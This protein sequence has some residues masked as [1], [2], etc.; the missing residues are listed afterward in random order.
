MSDDVAAGVPGGYSAPAPPSDPV[1]SM[2]NT[3]DRTIPRSETRRLVA[4]R[5]RFTGDLTAPRMLHAAFLRSPVA[6]GRIA[7]LDV[8]AARA[9]PGVAAV[10]TA[11]DLRPVCRPMVTRSA[12]VAEHRPPPQPALADGSVHYQG[13]PVALA[14]ADGLDRARDAAEAVRLEIDALP[15]ASDYADPAVRSRK[16][17]PE[18]DSNVMLRRTFGDSTGA[19]STARRRFVFERQ[20]GVPLEGRAVLADYDPSEGSLT[21][22][23]S[24]QVP[25]QMQDVWAGLLGLPLHRM[26][27][28]CPDVGGAFG[29]KL[30]AYADELA[31][32]AASRLLGR[33]VKWAADRLESFLSDVHAREFVIEAGLETGEDGALLAI[34][35]EM[36]NGAGAYSV[37]PRASA[38]E[39]SLTAAVIGAAYSAG[40][41]RV[42]A[43]ARAQNKTPTGAYRGVGQP[44]AMAVTEVL[45]D[46]AAHRLGLD[47]LDLRRR[48]Y[49]T[50]GA[51]FAST[52]G[53]RADALSLHACLDRL[54]A[55]MDYP[56]LRAAQA[57]AR[58]AGRIEGIGVATLIELTAPGAA[59][60]GAQEIDVTAEDT[61]TVAML[62]SGAVRVQ[63][64]CTDQGQGTL[65]GVGQL[66]GERLGLPPADVAVTAGD[67]AGPV[68][69]GAWASRGLAIGGTAAWRAAD[70]VAVRLLEIAATLLQ[71]DTANLRLAGGH[72]ID[73]SG[74]ARLPVAEIAKIAHYRQHL[75]P[76]ELSTDLSA[77]R[78]FVPKTAPF[79]AANGIHACHLAI[80]PETGAIDLLNHWVAEDCGRVINP[81]LVDGQ[82]IGG[83]VQGLGAALME[84][85]VYDG[86]GNLLTGSLMDYA[87]PRADWIPPIHIDH[88]ET[89]QP[90]SET[91]VK[92]A[93]EAGIIGAIAAVWCAVNDALR[94]LGKQATIQPF[95][96][97]RMLGALRGGEM[98]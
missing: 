83:V 21:V 77:S 95:T 58:K 22:F 38:G 17:H 46:D 65:T 94:P 54:E 57:A 35:A 51:P 41:V 61:A 3:T 63:V 97:E 40:R 62:P 20:T 2:D 5:G 32:V 34:D 85:C 56:A 64:G 50:D 8:S 89:L 84:R 24:G 47:P 42:A 48:N 26:R 81:A 18:T 1:P 67:S 82:I 28:V 98:K 43:E 16:A 6:H 70:A 31:V 33:P 80:D 27:V 71:E 49:P 87:L 86:D 39:A 72:V 75:L 30:H 45:I 37:H 29:I 68:G 13:Q 76:P 44:V 79:Y 90:G 36:E 7:A 96:P 91:G 12:T 69:G 4:G 15:P 23:Q 25:H 92:G 14:V 9:L 66:V 53:V 60:Y 74:A 11:D 73:G 52:G 88:I 59:I 78:S 55:L 93:G 10:L 19:T